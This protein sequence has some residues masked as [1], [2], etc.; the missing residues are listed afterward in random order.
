M[1]DRQRGALERRGSTGKVAMDRRAWGKARVSFAAMALTLLA[2]LGQSA[3]IPQAWAQSSPV[4]F[5]LIGDQ[6]PVSLSG[7][8]PAH[9]PTVGKLA[10]SGGVSGGSATYDIPIAVPPGR[11]GMQPGLSLNYSSRAGNG[12]A[13]MGWSLSG[14]SSM[15]RCPH[16]LE[17]DGQ[18]RAVQLD[19][20]DRLCLDG[21]RLVLTSGT[22]GAANATYGT[23]MESFVRVTQLGGDLV[24]SATYFKVERKSGEIAYYGN[25]NASAS[26]A[27]VV[28]GGVSVP[29]TWMIA[30]VED[31]VGN[32]M[33][34][35]YTAYGDGETL[36]NTIWYTGFAG[37]LGSR[38][39]IFNYEDRPAGAGMNDRSSS[40][41]AGGVT[42]QTKRLTSVLTYVD[43]TPVRSY[44]LSYGSAVSTT[45]G[46]S[47]LQSVSDCAHD[48]TSWVCKPP[49][50]FAWQQGAINY[51]LK[52]MPSG[53]STPTI[54]EKDTVRPAGDVDGDGA[55]EVVVVR[56]NSANASTQ[57]WVVS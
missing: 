16:T 11:R 56:R 33:D 4:P 50:T 44:V 17:Q 48:G 1:R 51:A 21:Q 39:V 25:T 10:G 13:G 6:T 7:S 27:R 8:L 23:E 49:T 28:P 32:G 5:D 55:P 57:L 34:Y 19:T 22:Y 29:L 15:H 20:G 37:A 18:I 47:L 24:S 35:A 52:T 26:A 53:L 9:D 12:I 54:D 31:R 30:R 38:R 14:L 43:S 41:L 42:R 2:G 46:R 3:G 40:Y 36:V 45:T